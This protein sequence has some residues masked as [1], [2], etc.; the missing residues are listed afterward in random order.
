MA[1]RTATLYGKDYKAV[2]SKIEAGCKPCAFYGK[3]GLC[4]KVEELTELD[5][6]EYIWK[7]QK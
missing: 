2:K 1:K 6:A 3:W 4:R 7:K 5:C